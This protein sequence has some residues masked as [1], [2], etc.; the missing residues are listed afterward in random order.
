MPA[1]N[2]DCRSTELRNVTD[3]A[4]NNNLKLNLTKSQKIIFVD[5]RR[6]SNFSAPATIPGLQRVQ[7]LKFSLDEFHT[8]VLI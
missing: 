3:W 2:M 1:V 6:K 7:V 5:K 8:A 4:R